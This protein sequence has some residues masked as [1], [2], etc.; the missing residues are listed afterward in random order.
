V[1]SGGGRFARGWRLARLSWNIVERDRSLLALP[2]LM[3]A[4]CVGAFAVFFLP[5]AVVASDSGSRMPL[6]AAA[7]LIAYPLN[8]ISTFFGVAFVA[9]LRRHFAGEPASVGDGL[10]F[11]RTR[12][13]AI[14]G[15]ALL[16]TVVGL[17]IRLL[18]RV[19]GG[20]LAARIA[21][22]LLGA[23]WSLATLFVL[24]VLASGEHPGAIASA[25]ESAA[26]ARRKWGETIVGSTVIGAA[27]TLL[28]LPV[29]IVFV[30]G[31][32][33]FASSPAFGTF[34]IVLAIALGLVVFVAQS[35]VDGVFRVVLFDYA[36][37]GTV[38]APFSAPDL[39]SGLRPKRKLFR[40]SS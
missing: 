29:A 8:F 24:P 4:A 26:I 16:A 2:A 33:S 32:A 36:T 23:L 12:L 21:G 19:R 6:L 22:F 14:A 1:Q 27:F 3:L 35:A 25:R 17:S 10:S 13:G 39:D 30:I 20:E 15:W 28:F 18:E 11:A 5:L 7:V 38:H 9:V 34:V 40:R 37:E 31:Y